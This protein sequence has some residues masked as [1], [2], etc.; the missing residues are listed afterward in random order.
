MPETRRERAAALLGAAA[1]AGA[2][3]AVAL[4]FRGRVLAQAE[5]LHYSWDAALHVLAGLDL[6]DD[7]RRGALL[8]ALFRLAAQHWWGPF[9]ALLTAPFH[10]LFGPGLAAATLPSL[11][12]FA[13]APAAAW[14]FARRVTGAAGLVAAPFVLVLFLR[15][16]LLL[17]ASAWPMFE[18]TGGFLSLS[19]WLLF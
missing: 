17:E 5:A 2:A 18:S 14:L 10:A 9:W 8:S 6:W 3:L 1:F 7:V 15:S 11:L 12:A 16:P 19:A 13:A 4:P